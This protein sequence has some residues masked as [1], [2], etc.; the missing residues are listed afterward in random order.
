[1]V[2]IARAGSDVSNSLAHIFVC[3]MTKDGA[4]LGAPT[5]DLYSKSDEICEAVGYKKRPGRLW[6]YPTKLKWPGSMVKTPNDKD[7]RVVWCAIIPQQKA[8]EDQDVDLS[9]EL[10]ASWIKATGMPLKIAVYNDGRFFECER[11]DSKTQVF[12][13]KLEKHLS[14]WDVEVFYPKF[15]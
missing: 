7:S 8:E 6:V 10:L 3:I 13:K 15:K 9:L 4:L 5:M 12:N 2:H 1:M 11:Y 14:D